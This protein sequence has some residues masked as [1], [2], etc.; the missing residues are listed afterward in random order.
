LLNCLFIYLFEYL[1]LDL[2][3]NLFDYFKLFYFKHAF[4]FS[5]PFSHINFS[6]SCSRVTVLTT[7]LI[8]TI[9]SSDDLDK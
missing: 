5:T 2:T 3:N 1:N 6:N 7:A 8:Q 9:Y 4:L